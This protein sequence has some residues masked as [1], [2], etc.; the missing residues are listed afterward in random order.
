ML[1]GMADLTQLL[2]AIEVGDPNAAEELL[3]LVYVE[4]R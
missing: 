3:P 2:T 1:G 4:L